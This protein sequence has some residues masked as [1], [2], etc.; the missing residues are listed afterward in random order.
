MAGACVI[1]SVST[2]QPS[3]AATTLL[4]AFPSRR[5]SIT[6]SGVA[7]LARYSGPPGRSWI[8]PD[9]F[10]T[11][12]GGDP[13]RPDIDGRVYATPLAIPRQWIENIAYTAYRLWRPFLR[14]SDGGPRSEDELTGTSADSSRE[15]FPR[16]FVLANIYLISHSIAGRTRSR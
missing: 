15:R 7:V 4:P 11:L 13:L 10:R 6:N 14:G 16:I 9:R 8:A 2:C 5:Y 3:G 12:R 1:P